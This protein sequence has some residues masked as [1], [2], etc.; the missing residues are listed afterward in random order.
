MSWED[1]LKEERPPPPPPPKRRIAPKPPPPK[2]RIEQFL[3]N[4]VYPRFDAGENYLNFERDHEILSS[5][6]DYH[7]P[8][9][10]TIGSWQNKDVLVR[11][12]TQADFTVYLKD[13][14]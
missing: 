11:M 13:R 1:I 5:F 12:N 4:E 6:F 14:R 10:R 2:G 8:N 3:Q 9:S 7:S